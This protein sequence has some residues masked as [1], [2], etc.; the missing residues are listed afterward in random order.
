MENFDEIKQY[1]SMFAAN[2]N[3]D[4][5]TNCRI[6]EMIKNNRLKSCTDA[7]IKKLVVIMAFLL[8]VMF[9]VAIDRSFHLIPHIEFHPITFIIAEL[10]PL[11]GFVISACE[12]VMLSKLDYA[13]DSMT[14][15]RRI[16]K[17]KRFQRVMTYVGIVLFAMFVIT[18]FYLQELFGNMN[19]IM[20]FAIGIVIVSIITYL[21]ILYDKKKIKEIE[22]GI[23]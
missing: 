3:S 15:K 16:E 22:E 9:F 8:V 23:G 6:L 17:L 1:W 20:T 13:E 10:M 19:A 5:E 7:M 18:F 2:A 11:I 4:N 14:M 12:V 21:E